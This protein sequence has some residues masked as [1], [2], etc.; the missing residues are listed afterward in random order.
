MHYF[1]ILEKYW[2]KQLPVKISNLNLSF[3]NKP[4]FFSIT[5]L[6]FIFSIK[7]FDDTIIVNVNSDIDLNEV[8][9][10][11]AFSL[12]YILNNKY[13]NGYIQNTIDKNNKIDIEALN[14]ALNLVLPTQNFKE[15]SHKYI[16]IQKI[17]ESFG[18]SQRIIKQKERQLKYS[19]L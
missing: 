12:Y 14:F 15:I 16:S 6:N 9:F 8:N 1:T 17:A 18:V 11:F 5:P 3:N 10:V 7:E 13:F 2:N 4:I 19:S